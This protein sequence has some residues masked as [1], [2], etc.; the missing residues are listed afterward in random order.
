MLLLPS[1]SSSSFSPSQWLE[2]YLGGSG[3]II[4]TRW[5]WRRKWCECLFLDSNGRTL[6]YLENGRAKVTKCRIWRWYWYRRRNKDWPGARCWYWWQWLGSIWPATTQGAVHSSCLDWRAA[7]STIPTKLKLPPP[8][9]R[10]YSDMV[11]TATVTTPSVRR[12]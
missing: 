4:T 6:W 3:I 5:S 8:R 12:I 2:S 10:Q 11:T 1:L 9:Q 7:T